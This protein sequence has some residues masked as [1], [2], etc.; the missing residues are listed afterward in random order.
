MRRRCVAELNHLSVAPEYRQHAVV[1]IRSRHVP[2]EAVL[3]TM[4]QPDRFE[5]LSRGSR[6]ERYRAVRTFGRRELTV[7]WRDA[8]THAVVI[9]AW[10]RSVRMRGGGR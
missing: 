9:T 1:R 8:G 2:R 7:I 4:R 5:V 6:D 10:W 3:L